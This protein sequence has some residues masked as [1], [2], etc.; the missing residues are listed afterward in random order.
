MSNGSDRVGVVRGSGCSDGWICKRPGM[1]RW[2]DR[3]LGRWEG[4]Q[5]VNWLGRRV[6]HSPLTTHL[7]ILG[8]FGRHKSARKL[9]LHLLDVGRGVLLVPSK[10][11]S[12][13]FCRALPAPS[14]N[15][16]AM[17]S[18]GTGF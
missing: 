6:Y 9:F 2:V 5:W 14:S 18:A 8:R 12:R 17:D 11:V 10:I 4:S 3:S 16:M 1:G 7:L 15:R 13:F